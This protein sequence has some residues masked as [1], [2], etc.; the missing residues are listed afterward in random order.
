MIGVSA[1]EIQE[2]IELIIII[3]FVCLSLCV[4]FHSLDHSLFLL[5]RTGGSQDSLRGVAPIP[6]QPTPPACGDRPYSAAGRC[7][8]RPYA[9]AA[10]GDQTYAARGQGTCSSPKGQGDASGEGTCSRARGQGNA[11]PAAAANGDRP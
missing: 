11:R 8:D 10:N 7:G 4:S 5:G 2:E 1:E 9:A 3:M 6:P